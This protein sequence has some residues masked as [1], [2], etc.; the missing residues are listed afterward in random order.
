MDRSACSNGS[1]AAAME[2]GAADAFRAIA[3]IAGDIAFIIDCPSG[4]LRYISPSVEQLLGHTPAA[5]KQQLACPGQDGPLRALCAGLPQRLARYAAGDTSRLRLVREWEVPA[6]SRQAV[7]VEVI[8]TLILGADGA[9]LALAGMIRDHSPSRALAAEQKR[10]ASML[11]HEFRTP[12]STIDGAIQRL[13]ATSAN[14]DEATRQRYRKIGA[15]VDR[16]I[17]MLDE[18]LSPDRM[19]ALGRSKPPAGIAPRQLLDEAAQLLQ[20]A[21]RPVRIQADALP[22][23]LRGD[24]QGLRLAVKVLVDNALA[25]SPPG[26]EVALSGQAVANGIELG[27]AD[28]GA[29]VPADDAARIFDKGFRGSNAA[30]IRG[31][32][33]GLYMARAVLEVHGGTIELVESPFGGAMFKIWLPTPVERG[34]VVDSHEPN[35]DNR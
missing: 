28:Q 19:A 17:G 35:R 3:E 12:L 29:G 13:E 7:P 15:A 2:T 8:S 26:S 32:G 21:G 31:N 11:N 4:D 16:L 24:P 20:A 10:F 14:A 9:P 23:T 25:F 34:K 1:G 18:Y 22:A 5:F 30:G 27:V 33:L 6:A